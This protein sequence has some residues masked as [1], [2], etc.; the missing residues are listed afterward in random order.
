M[1]GNV[2]SLIVREALALGLDPRAVIAVAKQEGGL[3]N[4]R[5][6]I[7][8]LSGGGS[9]GPF[10]LYAQGALPG[11]FRGKPA[12]ADAW[13]WSPAGIRY[14]LGRMASAGAAGLSGAAA[15]K[16][17]VNRFER[18]AN[19]QREIANA[20][21]T[22]KQEPLQDMRGRA[23]QAYQQGPAAVVNGP[24]PAQFQ[25]F[26]QQQVAGLLQ[27]SENTVAGDF[28]SNWQILGQLNTA[29]K[30]LLDATSRVSAAEADARSTGG[31][32]TPFGAGITANIGDPVMQKILTVADA[33]IGKPYVW[34]GESP[35][36]GGF[37]CSGLIDYAY[38][39]AG[40][41]LPGRLTTQTALK[42]G[43]SVKG[44][45]M[46][47][48]D[49]LI[50]NGG[51]HMVMYVGNGQVIAAPRRGL[52]VRYQPVADF[53]GDIVDVR[54]VNVRRAAQRRG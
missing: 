41:R 6:D 53:Q 4:R 37:D 5:G 16:A 33:Q 45:S 24:S 42:M 50:T 29:R 11:R 40:I 31:S 49:W 9:Y 22:M 21:Q 1:A 51:K 44:Q 12:Q 48:G 39:Q 52:A 14:A 18:P 7:G 23:G 26:Q 13:A 19:P 38:R 35:K 27:M 8:D 3:R 54:R 34:G 30:S 47:P 46:Q 20:I 15:I 2:T 10:Q 43:I 36:E 28:G 32:S 17:I 25:A